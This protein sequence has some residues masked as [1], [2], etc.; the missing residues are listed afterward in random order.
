MDSS[1]MKW[2]LPFCLSFLFAFTF[3]YSQEDDSESAGYPEKSDA[4]AVEV[5]N[6]AEPEAGWK[7]EQMPFSYQNVQVP[8][9]VWET[10]KSVL[11]DD[12]V[13]EAL[14]ESFSILP[15]SITMELTATE[16]GVLRNSFNYRLLY[17][18][19]GGELDL[20]NYVHKRGDFFIRFSPHLTDGYPFHLLYISDSPGKQVAGDSWGNGCGKIFNLTKASGRFILDRGMPMTAARRHYLHLMAGT[21]VFFQL[22]EEKMFIGYIRL[23]DSR[24]PQFKCGDQ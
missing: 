20:F 11:R 19:G 3:A 9:A 8:R 10:I 17:I 22:V 7:Y 6:T 18:E 16:M 2:I 5:A 21:Y 12:G 14:I 24:Y 23:T 15:I 4:A 13:K 1:S